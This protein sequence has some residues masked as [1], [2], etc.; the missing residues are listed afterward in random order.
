MKL[1]PYDKIIL[2]TDLSYQEAIDLLRDK[3]EKT[4]VLISVGSQYVFAGY[5]TENTFKV[6]RT[7]SY[8]SVKPVFNGRILSDNDSTKIELEIYVRK[9]F[10][11]IFFSLLT[12]IALALTSSILRSNS[13]A[14]IA[15]SISL[16][17]YLI[18]TKV[19]F[20]IGYDQD[21]YLGISEFKEIFKCKK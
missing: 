10:K 1:F 18:F 4:N 19:L 13:T 7:A 17:V 14:I 5:R 2:K 11:I 15:L 12:I 8:G 3:V 6:I 9:S 16:I 20:L 21:Y